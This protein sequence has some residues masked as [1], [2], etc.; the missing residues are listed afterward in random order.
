MPNELN[1]NNHW[2]FDKSALLGYYIPQE[3]DNVIS[4]FAT[5]SKGIFND[6]LKSETNT[7]LHKTF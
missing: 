6:L 5:V 2:H 4:H 3:L 7:Q 1:F